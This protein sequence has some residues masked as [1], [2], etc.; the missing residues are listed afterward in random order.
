MILKDDSPIKDQDLCV[1]IP[2]DTHPENKTA[3]NNSNPPSGTH[4]LRIV[5]DGKARYAPSCCRC[6]EPIPNPRE[7]NYSAFQ[8]IW[9]HPDIA[10]AVHKECDDSP[11][12]A[13]WISMDRVCKDRQRPSWELPDEHPRRPGRGRSKRRR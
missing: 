11:F 6:H 8:P 5:V 9:Q 10:Y 4:L 13:P 7:G 3:D 2:H 1:G 12:S